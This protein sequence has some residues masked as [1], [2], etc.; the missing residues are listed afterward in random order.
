MNATDVKCTEECAEFEFA[1]SGMDGMGGFLHHE[2]GWV[3]FGGSG[4]GGALVDCEPCS[5]CASDTGT[6]SVGTQED[7]GVLVTFAAIEA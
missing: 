2:S 4:G 5:P 6:R 1:A 3:V 7:E